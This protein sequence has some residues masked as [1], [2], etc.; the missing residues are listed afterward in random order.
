MHIG[1]KPVNTNGL[2]RI[3]EFVDAGKPVVGIRT[4]SHA[5]SLRNEAPPEGLLQVKWVAG[6][7]RLGLLWLPI[8]SAPS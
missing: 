6:L 8:I 4:A 1:N 5:F 3:R 2:K 7:R